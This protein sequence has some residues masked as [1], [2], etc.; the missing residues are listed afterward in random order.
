[1]LA[2][3]NFEARLIFGCRGTRR[4]AHQVC[5]VLS[6]ATLSV[7]PVTLNPATPPRLAGSAKGSSVCKA[8][9]Y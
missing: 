7:T 6:M 9:K 5:P 3:G 8:Q 2:G 4:P 1:M